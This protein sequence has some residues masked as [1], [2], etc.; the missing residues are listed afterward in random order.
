[1]LFLATPNIPPTCKVYMVQVNALK[2]EICD[3]EES[4]EKTMKKFTAEMYSLTV[5][6][7]CLMHGLYCWHINVFL[8]CRQVSTTRGRS[9][10]RRLRKWRSA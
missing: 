10:S 8:K 4:M 5:M 6:L 1:M 3:V 9:E 2:K 7:V